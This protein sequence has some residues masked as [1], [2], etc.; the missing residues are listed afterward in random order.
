[1][2]TQEVKLENNQK[3]AIINTETGEIIKTPSKRPNNLPNGK[4]KLNYVEFGMLN[5]RSSRILEKYFSNLELSIIFKMITRCS[6][7]TNSLQP[8][9]NNTSIRALSEEFNISINS[10][11][12]IFDKLYQMGVYLQ[13]NIYESNGE[14]E[15]WVLNPNIFWRGRMTND[16]IFSHFLNTDITKLLS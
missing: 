7:N 5:L 6:F 14:K 12:K 11:P 9:S 10:V 16:S 1:M 2:Y 15:Y 4:S 13:L 8:L 3:V